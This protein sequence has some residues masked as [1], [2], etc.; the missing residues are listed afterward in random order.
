MGQWLR[1]ESFE[2]YKKN[3]SRASIRKSLRYLGMTIFLCG[4]CFSLFIFTLPIYT[5]QIL[6]TSLAHPTV[7]TAEAL[8]SAPHEIIAEDFGL[9]LT[10]IED[11]GAIWTSRSADTD[12][13]CVTATNN[14]YGYRENGFGSNFRNASI[15]FVNGLLVIGANDLMLEADSRFDNTPYPRW[16]TYGELQAGIHLIEFH[17]RESFGDEPIHI[18]QWAIQIDE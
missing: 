10:I 17:L 15:L 1:T 8:L 5:G 14:E 4:G 16:C 13:I 9:Y 11:Y 7:P 2:K 18:Q 12:L 3:D 6:R